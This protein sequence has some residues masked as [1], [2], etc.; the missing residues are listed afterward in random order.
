MQA[1]RIYEAHL[2]DLTRHRRASRGISLGVIMG[3]KVPGSLLPQAVSTHTL[4]KAALAV[5]L[6]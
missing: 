5:S 3:R 1:T 6:L 2:Q 4:A